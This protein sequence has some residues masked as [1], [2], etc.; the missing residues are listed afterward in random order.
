MFRTL[1]SKLALVLAALFVLVGAAITLAFVELLDHYNLEATQRMNRTLAQHVLDQN[2]L[3]GGNAFD[4]SKLEAMFDMQRAINPAIE[5]YLLTPDGTIAAS[6]A[7]P[8]AR[9]RTRVSIEPIRQF[10]DPQTRLPILGDDPLAEGRRRV[11]S[12]AEVPSI[13]GVAGYLYVVLASPRQDGLAGLLARSDIVRILVVVAAVAVLFAMLSGLVIFGFTTRRVERL[14]DAMESFKRDGFSLAPQ[15]AWRRGGDEIDRLTGSFTELA[16]RMVRQLKELKQTDVLRREL[17]ANVS[18][19][20]KTPLAALQGYVDTLLLK[21]SNL[22]AEERRNY[23]QIASRSGERLNKLVSDLIELAKLDANEVQPAREPFSLAELAQDVAQKFQVT[24]E[25]R[26][27]RVEA[28]LPAAAPYVCGDIALIERVLEN[29]VANAVAHTDPG[30]WVRLRIEASED[31]ATA[32]VED[33]GC[34]IPE[35][36]LDRIFDRFYRVNEAQRERGNHSGLGLA[37]VKSI[38][39]LHGSRVRVE[40]APGEGSRFSFK[41]PAAAGRSCAE[42]A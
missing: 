30:G 26:R 19:D 7:G 25:R 10:L 41:L 42:A 9:A 17:V 24:A 23:L 6:S 39:E 37:I 29:L 36:E 18:H 11:F 38:V 33:S 40:S 21:D 14:A 34:G 12:A 28:S 3:A 5:I 27:I 8:A 13:G 16:A 32:H 31:G 20:L 2:G 15:L 35:H 22:A 1:Y 4:R